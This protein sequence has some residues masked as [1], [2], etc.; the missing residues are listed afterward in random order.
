MADLER[1]GGGGQP[2]A[3]EARSQ[4]FVD[5]PTSGHAGSPN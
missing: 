3:R 2:L 4:I 5:T 1:G